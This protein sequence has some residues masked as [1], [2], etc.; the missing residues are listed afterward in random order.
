[1]DVTFLED[2]SFFQKNYLQEEMQS[3]ED[4]SLHILHKSLP[5][6]V[7]NSDFPIVAN[8]DQGGE[9]ET[10]PQNDQVP[11]LDVPRTGGEI[12]QPPKEPIVWTRRKNVCQ[13]G[14]QSIIQAPS[15]STCP[16]API[17]SSTSNIPSPNS[18]SENLDVSISIALRKGTRTYT[19]I[20]CSTNHPISNFMSYHRL[21]QN[22]KAY[23][24]RITKLFVPR[25]IQ[26]ALDDPNW[27]LA[28]MEEMSALEKNETWE[29]VELPQD[30]KPVGCK[31]IFTIKCKADGSVD[32]YKARL[33]AK[34]FTQT[35]GVDYEET[36]APVAKINS[37]RILLS[38]A[39]N[40][41]WP[42]HQLDV[43]NAFLNGDLEEVFISSPPGFDGN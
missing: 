28:V 32:R 26:E 31:W 24:S 17:M 15:Q 10:S 19:K 35:Y 22:H 16:E 33:V 2:Q 40:F 21:S 39:V 9:S 20:T 23:T 12:P 37:I 41:D 6:T 42:L 43:K 4:N 5:Q 14:S 30:K 1:M 29:I 8:N 38:L 36:F 11:P 13:K 18:N 3:D 27:K 34:G 25:N 7:L